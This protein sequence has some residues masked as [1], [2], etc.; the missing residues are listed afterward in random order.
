MLSLFWNEPNRFSLLANIIYSIRKNE[1]TPGKNV[2][3]LR[4]CGNLNSLLPTIVYQL[5]FLCHTWKLYQLF[6]PCH[7]QSL[8]A[9]FVLDKRK[10]KETNQGRNSSRFFERFYSHGWSF[11]PGFYQTKKLRSALFLFHWGCNLSW[12]PN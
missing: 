11:K 1:K 3:I 7:L 9:F 12:I 2:I 6:E 8:A 4:L 10:K 5:V